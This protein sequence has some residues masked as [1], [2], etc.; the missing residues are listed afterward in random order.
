ME[1]KN[2]RIPLLLFARFIYF[3]RHK[4]FSTY[5]V[6]LLLEKW[7]WKRSGKGRCSIL[8]MSVSG[9]LRCNRTEELTEWW[10]GLCWYCIVAL[11]PSSLV[12]L[13]CPVNL[14]IKNTNE[15]DETICRR[16]DIFYFVD[17]CRLCLEYYGE[18]GG[19]WQNYRFF[20]VTYRFL[21][22]F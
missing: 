9:R 22:S 3:Q 4:H 7:I 11:F 1:S 5:Q 20:S 10:D 14:E 16:R 8:R 21:L 19:W 12:L 17:M 13:L 18:G 2:L 15:T 6:P